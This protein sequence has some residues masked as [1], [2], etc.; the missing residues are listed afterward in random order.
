MMRDMHVRKMVMC[1]LLAALICLLTLVHI[2][3]PATGGYI[4][5]G[6]GMIMA[7]GF[8]LGGP[9]AG[10]AAGLGSLLADI[11]VGA[12]FYAPATFVIKLLMGLLAGLL[13][14]TRN[15]AVRIGIMTLAE[16]IMM[17]G[18][19][20]FEGVTVGWAAAAAGI[21]MNAIQAVG[22]IAIGAALIALA[23]KVLPKGY[24]SEES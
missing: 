21:Y 6:D 9:L 5:P 10:L 13:G 20:V 7:A 18:Y 24:L 17:G 3:I 1:A 15:W 16:L 23:P 14:K 4:H 11:L 2:T 12:A 8:L 22:G 19:L